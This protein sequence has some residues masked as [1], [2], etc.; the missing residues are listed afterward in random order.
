MRLSGGKEYKYYSFS[1]RPLRLHSTG[2]SAY[3]FFDLSFSDFGTYSTVFLVVRMPQ[4]CFHGWRVEDSDSQASY[5]GERGICAASDHWI[6]M[7]PRRN[8]KKMEWLE[9]EVLRHL[10]WRNEEPSPFISVSTSE[11]WAF[12]EARRRKEQEKKDVVVYEIRAEE[13]R[14]TH[15]K[16]VDDLL[17]MAGSDNTRTRTEYLFLHCIPKNFIVKCSRV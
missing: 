17:K 5:Q 7:Y 4:N 10:D 15:W 6:P 14:N 2:Y 12:K 8:E 3:I 13:G 9:D 1:P 16:S 11:E